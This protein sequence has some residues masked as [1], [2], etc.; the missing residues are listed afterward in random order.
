MSKRSDAEYLNDIREAINRLQA[1]TKDLDY[2]KF[3]KDIKTQDAV[4][5]NLEIIGEAVKNIS[6][7]LQ[8]KHKEVAW[9]DLAQVRDKL[10]HHYFGVNFDIVWGI[11]EDSLP[12][13]FIQI[14]QILI[15]DNQ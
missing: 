4:V 7:G 3:V 8:S 10:I 2:P 1:Y 15:E 11:I 6:R 14:N 12:K 13:I 9:K 5:R